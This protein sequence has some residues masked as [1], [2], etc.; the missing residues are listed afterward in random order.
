L[1]RESGKMTHLMK[2]K[3]AVLFEP[4]DRITGILISDYNSIELRRKLKKATDMFCSIN[5]DLIERSIL[6][7]NSIAE[8]C[9]I[10]ELISIFQ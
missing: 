4:R 6:Y 2:D 3:R 5:H 7:N 10:T 1:I 8:V 9:D